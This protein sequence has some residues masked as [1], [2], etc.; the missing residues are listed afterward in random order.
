MAKSDLVATFGDEAKKFRELME[1]GNNR[2]AGSSPFTSATSAVSYFYTDE[3]DLFDQ[4]GTALEDNIGHASDINQIA[5]NTLNIVG[6]VSDIGD[7]ASDIV[8][9]IGDIDD[10]EQ[11]VNVNPFVNGLEKDG[12]NVLTLVE[13]PQTAF[14]QKS[15]SDTEVGVYN[16]NYTT[17]IPFNQGNFYRVFKV[18][19]QSGT[20]DDYWI[21]SDLDIQSNTRIWYAPDASGLSRAGESSAGILL[22]SSDDGGIGAFTGDTSDDLIW[23]LEYDKD[24]GSN[25]QIIINLVGA[26]GYPHNIDFDVTIIAMV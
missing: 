20:N 26:G 13:D 8:I 23:D 17:D 18:L 2:G 22:N 21:I 9:N 14:V 19:I 11:N 15:F 16:N 24:A 7:N 10:L 4:L 3:D 25:G 5:T 1:L 12:S 6:N